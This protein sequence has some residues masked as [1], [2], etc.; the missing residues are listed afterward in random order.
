MTT[1]ANGADPGE[2]N[3]L[4]GDIMSEGLSDFEDAPLAIDNSD[5]INKP[6]C[7]TK[8]TGDHTNNIFWR[9]GAP[10]FPGQCILDQMD[11]EQLFVVLQRVPQAAA[12]L[13]RIT[14]DPKLL[15]LANTIPLS[16]SYQ[17]DDQ[18]AANMI[19]KGRGTGAGTLP[20]YTVLRGNVGGNVLGKGGK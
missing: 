16:V 7:P 2:G 6:N 12:D 5:P 18:R 15:T 3:D 20:Y 4:G 17:E 8:C 13:R 14:N 9:E 11:F 1:D 10:G 19:N